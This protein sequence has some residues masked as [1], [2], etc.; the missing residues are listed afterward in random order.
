VEAGRGAATPIQNHDET[1]E[2]CFS[3]GLAGANYLTPLLEEPEAEMLLAQLPRLG[4]LA[5]GRC[6]AGYSRKGRELV[7]R[8][9]V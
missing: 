2:G 1:R 8:G 5:C 4:R 3:D 7:E 9:I 6:G